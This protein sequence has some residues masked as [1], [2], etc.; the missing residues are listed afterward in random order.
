MA[1]CCAFLRC[2]L[3]QPSFICK[4]RKAM[5]VNSRRSLQRSVH[6]D[7]HSSINQTIQWALAYLKSTMH[8]SRQH[9]RGSHNGRL[10]LGLLEIKARHEYEIIPLIQMFIRHKEYDIT[11][12]SY[13]FAVYFKRKKRIHSRRGF[14]LGYILLN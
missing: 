6:A 2:P 10:N 4:L 14:V 1:P 9:P 7:I 11:M 12:T 3:F 5:T 8:E 13:I